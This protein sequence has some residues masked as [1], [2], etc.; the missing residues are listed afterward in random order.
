MAISFVGVGALAAAGTSPLAPAL[1]THSVGDLLLLFVYGWVGEPGEANTAISVAGWDRLG[2][3]E[4]YGGGVGA[5]S[6]GR[7]QI[8]GKFAG[9]GESAPSVTT[10]NTAGGWCAFVA[11]YSGVHADILDSGYS[12]IGSAAAATRTAETAPTYTAGA[13]QISFVAAQGDRI[14]TLTT[15]QGF[16]ARASGDDY[17]VPTGN[18]MAVAIADQT[19]AS[20]GAH[21]QPTWTQTSGGPSAWLAGSLSLRAADSTQAAFP[22]W[23]G[24]AP[25]NATGSAL[26]VTP[27]FST[28]VLQDD[29]LVVS[30]FAILNAGTITPPDGTW[31]SLFRFTDIVNLTWEAFYKVATGGETD[32]TFTMATNDSRSTAAIFRHVDTTSPLGAAVVKKTAPTAS[33]S[34]FTPDP[35]TATADNSLA[36]SY[37]AAYDAALTGLSA[38]Q[39]FLLDQ[40]GI[41][42]QRAGSY[43]D[44]SVI[45]GAVTQPTWTANANAQFYGAAVLLSPA[46]QPPTPPA[47][48]G[49]RMGGT[50]AIRKPPRYSR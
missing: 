3:V 8:F 43:A 49:N 25:R 48:G 36:V 27:K 30:V 14:V 16:T 33:S 50:G 19:F 46:P 17:S 40:W 31:T 44:R 21:T 5:E 39:G 24:G 13:V 23:V 37:V 38:A 22:T 47:G 34:S 18:G 2:W 15:A 11:A 4:T 26:A 41:R 9:A 32:A 28:T 29:L 35:I 10:S 6:A 45:A 1:P 7:T 20:P 42:F 12:G